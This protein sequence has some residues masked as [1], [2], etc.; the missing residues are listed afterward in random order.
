M[1]LI[2]QTKS[3]TAYHYPIKIQVNSFRCFSLDFEEEE[4]NNCI[5]AGSWKECQN[6][7]VSMSLIQRL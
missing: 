1:A 2:V 3:S 4:K 6:R 5:P 7:H